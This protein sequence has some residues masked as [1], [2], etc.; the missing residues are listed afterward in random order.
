MRFLHV[1]NRKKLVFLNIL[2]FSYIFINFF[3]GDRGFFSY[4]D[5]KNQKESLINKKENL[6]EKLNA[7]ERK[8]KLLS[9]NLNFDFLETILLNL[10]SFHFVFNFSK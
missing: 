3:D 2:L 9:E 4:S 6:V 7:I 8:N 1:L 10:R 5:K